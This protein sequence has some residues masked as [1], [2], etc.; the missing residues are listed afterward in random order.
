M[1]NV[2]LDDIVSG[3]KDDVVQQATKMSSTKVESASARDVDDYI[4]GK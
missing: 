4:S 3:E 2:D 1:Q